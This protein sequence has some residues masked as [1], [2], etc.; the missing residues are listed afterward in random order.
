[1]YKIIF[2]KTTS[3]P[4][5]NSHGLIGEKVSSKCGLLLLVTCRLPQHGESEA[6]VQSLIGGDTSLSAR[7]QKVSFTPQYLVRESVITLKKP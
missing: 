3:Y 5:K 1:M 6:N 7:G 2:E 4:N